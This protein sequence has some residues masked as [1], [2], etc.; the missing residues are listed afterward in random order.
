MDGMRKED[1]AEGESQGEE[2]RKTARIA[3][4]GKWVKA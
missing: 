4:P 1:Q 2:V 3:T